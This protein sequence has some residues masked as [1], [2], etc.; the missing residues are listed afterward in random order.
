MR[1]LLLN[2]SP[3]GHKSNSRLILSWLC[4]GLSESAPTVLDLAC[5]SVDDARQ[6]FVDAEQVVL[7]FPLYT[8]A[9]PALV[10][11]FIESLVEVD[12]ARLRGKQVAFIIQSGFPEAIHTETLATYLARLCVRLGFEHLGT[13]NKGGIE[14]IRVMPPRMVRK[15]KEGFVRAGR[16]LRDQGRFSPALVAALAGRRTL[17]WWGRLV[18]RALSWIGGGNFY[19]NMM[20]KQH[21]AFARRFDKP[22]ADAR[23]GA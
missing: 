14:G 8:D 22:Y 5:T 2:G 20:L 6:A 17:G 3:R 19:W 4:E 16:E 10:K 12:R 1:R 13:I 23:P 15:T 18:F 21:G 7:A 9:M 11:R